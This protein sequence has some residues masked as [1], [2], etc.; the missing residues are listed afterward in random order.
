VWQTPIP[1]LAGLLLFAIIA[2]VNLSIK[3]VTQSI[4]LED[5]QVVISK[6]GRLPLTI[7]LERAE[8]YHV[9]VKGWWS[10]ITFEHG[11]NSH[12]TIW[13]YEFDTESWQTILEYV[14][15][16]ITF[17]KPRKDYTGRKF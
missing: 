10:G 4:I 1:F 13:T 14:G 17:S 9:T 15:R 5:S 8:V 7:D 3:G 16:R 2:F 11:Q 6:R 12:E